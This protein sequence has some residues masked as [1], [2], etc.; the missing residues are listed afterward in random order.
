MD[1]NEVDKRDAAGERSFR[2]KSLKGISLVKANLRGVDL[3][4]TNLFE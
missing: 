3:S 2:L 4:R 1:A